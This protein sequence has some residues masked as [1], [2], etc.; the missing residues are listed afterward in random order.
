M[1]VAL[2][3]LG[4]AGGAVL[5]YLVDHRVQRSHASAFPWGTLTVN[6]TGSGLLGLVTAWVFAGGDP[7]S[8]DAVRA[9]A[10]AGLCGSMTTFSTFGYDTVRLFAGKAHLHAV[11]NV[12]LTVLAG[13]GAAGAGLVLGTA[14]WG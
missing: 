2:V 9:F 14:L 4:G 7:A 10:G 8:T 13:F 12:V 6:I 3:L 5:R 1:T 11:A